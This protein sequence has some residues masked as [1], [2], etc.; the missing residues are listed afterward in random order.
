MMP[1]LTNGASAEDIRLL[2]DVGEMFDSVDPVPPAAVQ[3]G[4]AAFTWRT[5]DAE[6]A[7]LCEDSMLAGSA[8]GGIRGS[9]TRLLTFEAPSVNV[10]VEVTDIG[11]RRKLVGQVIPVLAGAL[12]IEHPAGSTTVDVDEQGLFSAESVPSGPA[13]IALSVPGGGA[14][15]TS[16]VTV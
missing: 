7:E 6:F 13:R 9:D 2:T 14:V 8:A 11:E 1:N 4:Y 5:M 3:A 10:V 16:W 12:R 15:V